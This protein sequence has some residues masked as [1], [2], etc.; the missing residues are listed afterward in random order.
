MK[1]KNEKEE[2]K[3]LIVRTGQLGVPSRSLRPGRLVRVMSM[4]TVLITSFII[5]FKIIIILYLYMFI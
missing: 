4:K 3:S 5:L 1:E 2:D